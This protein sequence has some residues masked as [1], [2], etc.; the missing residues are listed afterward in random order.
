MTTLTTIREKLEIKKPKVVIDPEDEEPVYVH[1]K[2]DHEKFTFW[3]RRKVSYH[4]IWHVCE[5]STSPFRSSRD[6]CKFRQHRWQTDALYAYRLRHG[7]LDVTARVNRVGWHNIS[8][9]TH[10]PP[11]VGHWYNDSDIIRSWMDMCVASLG[12]STDTP[13]RHHIL[14]FLGEVDLN[15]AIPGPLVAG[16]RA[17]HFM[18]FMDRTFGSWNKKAM[19]KAVAQRLQDEDLTT[20]A[21]GAM[22]LRRTIP[23]DLVLR[24]MQESRVRTEGYGRPFGGAAFPVASRDRTIWSEIQ[25]RMGARR[26][27]N[28]MMDVATYE[29]TDTMRMARRNLDMIGNL[30][31]A[32]G[33]FDFTANNFNDLHNARRGR[34]N[35]NDWQAEQERRRREIGGQE[36]DRLPIHVI[37][38]EQVEDMVVRVP[39]TTDEIVEWSEWMQHCIWMYADD[40]VRGSTWLVGLFRNDKLKS[41]AEIMT[42]GHIRQH[43]GKHNS[44]V[45][46]RYRY[47]LEDLLY[48]HGIAKPLVQEESARFV[49]GDEPILF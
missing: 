5:P 30:D 35:R 29:I 2:G 27:I 44:Q 41:T 33:V 10:L 38:G 28:A 1:V 34:V 11:F 25:R 45:E 16:F 37:D 21:F 39:T 31:R 49:R 40:M 9:S 22:M 6:D 7:Y 8:G 20:I 43:Y 36:I 19:R 48:R 4:P 13:I 23:Y 47:G 3:K 42:N 12:L 26:F 15:D 46:D 18:E 14:P 17:T 32:L 24:F